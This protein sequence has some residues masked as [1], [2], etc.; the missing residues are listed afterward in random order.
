MSN[1]EDRISRTVVVPFA[2][3]TA[4]I[5]V[6]HWGGSD[7]AEANRAVDHLLSTLVRDTYTVIG[8]I[9]ESVA[10][11]APVAG[12]AKH[13]STRSMNTGGAVT[14][15]AKV[16][17]VLTHK[18]MAISVAAY[19]SKILSGAELCALHLVDPTALDEVAQTVEDVMKKST[20]L[21]FASMP[22]GLF[23][24]LFGSDSP[25]GDDTD[26]SPYESAGYRFE[27]GQRS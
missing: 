20:S 12:Y 8:N 25:F 4:T 11:V 17:L 9:A 3:G 13:V 10:K 15:R 19:V 22:P 24:D 2:N 23:A 7:K 21:L 26:G 14:M 18:A 1:F 5:Q 16:T 6:D 27:G